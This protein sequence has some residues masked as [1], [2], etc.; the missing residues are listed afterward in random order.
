MSLVSVQGLS[1]TFPSEKGPVAAVRNVSFD[2]KPG[3]ILGIVGESGSGKSVT[4]R[5][6]LGLLP[7]RATIGGRMIYDGRDLSGPAEIQAVRGREISM[8]FQNPASHLDP[9]MTIGDHVAEPLRFH[10]GLSAA[11]ARAEAL[12]LL[13]S[14]RIRDAASRMDAWPHQLSGGMKQRVL[15]ASALACKPRLLLADEPTTALD[16]T[17]QAGILQLLRDLNRESGLTMALVSHDLGVIAEI[18][19][20]VIVMRGGEVIESGPVRDVVT[21]PQH[22]YTRLL[23]G[24]Q[25]GRLPQMAEPQEAPAGLV[26]LKDVAVHFPT[27]SGGG[28]VRAVDGVNLS[29]RKGEC[30]GIVGESGS[31]KSTVARTI[32]RLITPTGGRVMFEGKSVA[33]LSGADLTAYR[34][35][36]QMVF[37]SPFDSLNP[38]MTAQQTI[39]EP[40]WRHGLAS[41]SAAMERALEL[42]DMVELPRSFATRRPRA[43]S[44]G[45]CQRVGIARALALSPRL[46]IA[47]EVTSALDVTVQAQILRLLTRLRKE[48]DLTVIYIS[49]DLTVVRKFCDRV[50]VF[51]GGR[52]VETGA[53]A[54]LFASPSTEYTRDLIAAAPDM[55]QA[56]AERA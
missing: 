36:V 52:L 1:V 32:V 26:D 35:A 3:E 24:A 33:D 56:M 40:I 45:Q 13:E 5:A 53:T 4:C 17:V 37:Q 48:H 14:V 43:L 34:R 23:I 49:H 7:R 30:F 10:F 9:L 42:M 25:P 46:L 2:L 39:A 15:I 38:R 27:R 21:N 50:A 51:Q 19:D 41:K 31:G 54:D 55:D 12:K 18:C 16:V 11:E 22:E 47:D 29:V 28:I 44:G 8:I 20:R 6:L